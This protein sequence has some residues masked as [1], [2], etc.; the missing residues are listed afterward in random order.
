V[1]VL[2]SFPT[3]RSSDLVIVGGVF[4]GVS[5]EKLG[6]GVLVGVDTANVG[7]RVTVT[8]GV[9]TEKL[10]VGV[11]EGVSAETVAV[12]VLVGAE[13]PARSEE[14]TSELQSLA[15]L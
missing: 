14:H 10:G 7:V 4:V 11:L 15:Y 8:V 5:T 1:F 12:R 13:V 6:V 2:H 9:S 3:R